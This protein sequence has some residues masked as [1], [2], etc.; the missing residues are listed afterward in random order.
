MEVVMG[1]RTQPQKSEGAARTTAQERVLVEHADGAPHVT[2]DAFGML[3]H[4]NDASGPK[5]EIMGPVGPR[6]TVLA[7]DPECPHRAA[8]ARDRA[9][10]GPAQVASGAYRENW[11]AIF[12][13]K[14]KERAS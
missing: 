9:S 1:A 10:S 7:L 4:Y 12:G 5:G 13:A 11:D 8:R 2:V 3:R 6:G 14:R